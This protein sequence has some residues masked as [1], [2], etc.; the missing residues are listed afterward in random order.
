[1]GVDKPTA[2]ITNNKLRFTRIYS[3]AEA[4]HYARSKLVHKFLDR[5]SAG[6]WATQRM[7]KHR[8]SA[9]SQFVYRKYNKMELDDFVARLRTKEIDPYD[10]LGDFAIFLFK[11]RENRL[12]PNTLRLTV[13]AAKRFFDFYDIETHK[14]KD[15]VTLPAAERPER[16]ALSK[17]DVIEILN[18]LT[19]IRMKTYIMFLAVTGARAQEA[20]AVTLDDLDLDAEPATVIFRWTKTKDQRK[21]YLSTELAKQVR[22]WLKIKY[23][24]HDTANESGHKWVIPEPKPRD[25]IFAKWHSDGSNPAPLALYDTLRVEFAETLEAID[26][27]DREADSKRRKITFHTFRRFVKSTYSDLGYGDF[28]EWVIGHRGGIN[29]TYYSKPEKERAEVFAK[30]EPYLTYLDVT[31]LEAKGADMMTKLEQKDAEIAALRK[32]QTNL[33]AFVQSLIDSGQLKPK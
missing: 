28:G 3:Q 27:A 9:L 12:A 7:F 20:C 11:E 32:R 5:K 8:L 24:P 10:A 29:M 16:L 22:L 18:S 6:P 23:Q 1:L 2:I 30:V 4:D 33:E 19:D 26:M 21:R 25:L 15:K 13:I 17:A 14:F 31:A